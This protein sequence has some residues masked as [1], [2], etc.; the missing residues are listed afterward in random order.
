MN[1]LPD[2]PRLDPTTKEPM[3]CDA[4][5]GLGYIDSDVAGVAAERWCVLCHGTGYLSEAAQRE[6]A[7]EERA[8]RKDW[9]NE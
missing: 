9:R 5:D 8:E 4:C 1:Q 7:D 6:I 2:D 3:T